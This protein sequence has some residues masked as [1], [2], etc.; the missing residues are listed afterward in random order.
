[1]LLCYNLSHYY[2]V[3]SIYIMF[4][5]NLK[6]YK[7]LL[8]SFSSL[9]I[10]NECVNEVILP[11]LSLSTTTPFLL[12]SP[13]PLRSNYLLSS[14]SFSSSTSSGYW[15]LSGPP[16]HWATSDPGTLKDIPTAGPFSVV[17]EGKIF[18]FKFSLFLYT[19][20]IYSCGYVIFLYHY[21]SF[22]KFPPLELVDMHSILS[23]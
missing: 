23:L 2:I 6:I 22:A 8:P 3:L 11:L 12:S 16:E 5:I 1:M 7:W 10:L 21:I 15:S 4:I 14:S 9:L 20:V 18:L 17:C 13:L 19:Y